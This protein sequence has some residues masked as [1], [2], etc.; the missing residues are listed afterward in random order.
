MFIRLSYKWK[1]QWLKY[2]YYTI[3][4]IFPGLFLLLWVIRLIISESSRVPTE[5]LFLGFV[6][7]VYISFNYFRSFYLNLKSTTIFFDRDYL[8]I[9]NNNSNLLQIPI[10]KVVKIHGH[11]YDHN[12]VIHVQI[13]GE[14]KKFHFLTTP[15]RIYGET[16]NLKQLKKIISN[17]QTT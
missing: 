15:F 4:H 13:N 16:K 2:L 10:S 8:Y 14:V 1:W 17:G 7:G 3:R 6:L 5:A 11:R 12:Y 9:G